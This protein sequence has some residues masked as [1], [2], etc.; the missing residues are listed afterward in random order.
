[1][2]RKLLERLEKDFGGSA[3][4]WLQ[5]ELAAYGSDDIEGMLVAAEKAYALAPNNPIVV[6]NYA[7]ALIIMRQRPAEAVKLTLSKFSMN[8]GD[9]GSRLNHALALLQNERANEAQAALAV[10][11]P[12]EL[13]GLYHTVYCLAQYELQVLKG[14]PAKARDYARQIQ[15][16]FLKPPQVRWL[17]ESLKKLNP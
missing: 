1:L 4:Y 7:A 16:R 12:D 17:D 8:P 10:V 2:A 14:D 3:D 9:V 6:N 13:E 5:V 15:R 11:N